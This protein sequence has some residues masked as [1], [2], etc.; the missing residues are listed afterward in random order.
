VH[1]IYHSNTVNNILYNIDNTTYNNTI[2]STA[3]KETWRVIDLPFFPEVVL[4]I[5]MFIQTVGGKSS[6]IDIFS[7]IL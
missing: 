5:Y 1:T 4:C 2:C 3:L 6:K 7:S